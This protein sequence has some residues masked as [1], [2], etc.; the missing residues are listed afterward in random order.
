SYHFKSKETLLEEVYTR[1]C[2]FSDA[3][4]KVAALAPSGIDRVLHLVR[5]HATAHANALSGRSTPLALIS[6]IAALALPEQRM[7]GKRYKDHIQ[8]FKRFLEEGREDRSIDI[9]SID[10][11]AFFIFSVLH[12]MPRWLGNI[13]LAQ[14]EEAIDELCDTLRYGIAA[15]TEWRPASAIARPSDEP[16]SD[17]FDRDMR[18][19]MKRDAFLRTGTRYLNRKGFRSVSLNDI[20]NELGVTRGAFY[21]YIEDKEA[22]IEQCFDRTCDLIERSQSM[23]KQIARDA[24]GEL[25]GAIRHLFE[26]HITELDPL[27]RLSLVNALPMPQKASVLARMKR[28]SASFAET[29]ARAMVDGSARPLS[30]EAVEHLVVG[31]IFSASRRRLGFTSLDETWRPAEQPFTA[32]ADYFEVLFKGLAAKRPN[33]SQK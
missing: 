28:L 5:A 16:I 1:A 3:E 31:S 15:S 30:L 22:L 4:L 2:E 26:C 8:A 21:Y 10:A 13:P 24:L 9:V 20:A 19:Q 23:A 27:V 11:S 7:I 14:H 12:W 32:S 17:L 29:L 6:D 33:E 25:E 18:N